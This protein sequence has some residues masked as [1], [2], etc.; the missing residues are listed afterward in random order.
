M[1]F[2]S[3]NPARMFAAL[4]AILG[5]DM[6]TITDPA[7]YIGPS[8]LFWLAATFVTRRRGWL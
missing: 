4:C 3:E 5:A 7:F 1:G 2:A 6:Q 8:V